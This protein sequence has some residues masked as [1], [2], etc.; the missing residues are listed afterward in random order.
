MAPIGNLNRSVSAIVSIFLILTFG[1]GIFLPSVA[2]G[3][4]R[5]LPAQDAQEK[6][7]DGDPDTPGDIEGG[8]HTFGQP[9]LLTSLRLVIDVLFKT[10]L[11][12]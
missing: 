9:E 5:F 2:H 3:Y 7:I 4:D 6:P 10:Q 1:V 12:L 11:F 8:G